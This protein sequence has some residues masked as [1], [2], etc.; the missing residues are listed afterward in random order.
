M[1]FHQ[2]Y[3]NLQKEKCITLAISL[4]ATTLIKIVKILPIA[5][6]YTIKQLLEMPVN[7]INKTGK[8]E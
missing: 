7:Y 5:N 1:G 8:E 4:H 3:W 6:K 2:K